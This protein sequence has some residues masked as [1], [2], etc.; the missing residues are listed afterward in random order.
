MATQDPK[1]P[2]DLIPLSV[3]DVSLGIRILGIMALLTA[4]LWHM[5]Y[6]CNVPKLAKK[7]RNYDSSNFENL[8]CK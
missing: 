6:A 3:L 2:I 4:Y 5:S 7:T 8:P 1:I